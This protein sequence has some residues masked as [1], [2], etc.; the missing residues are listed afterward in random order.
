MRSKFI[1]WLFVQCP[2]S[3]CLPPSHLHRFDRNAC[4]ACIVYNK[5]DSWLVVWRRAESQR[6]REKQLHLVAHYRFEWP[7]GWREMKWHCTN[8]GRQKCPRSM[9]II[10]S[11]CCTSVV[12]AMATVKPISTCTKP[13]AHLADGYGHWPLAHGHGRRIYCTLPTANSRNGFIHLAV[14]VC[15]LWM[16]V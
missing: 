8:K 6:Q 11:C 5:W 12:T 14:W 4:I 9:P 1:I 10:S 2:R 13:T 3:D 15:G 7:H 16:R